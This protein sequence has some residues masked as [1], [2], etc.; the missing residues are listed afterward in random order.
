[1]VL[2]FHILYCFCFFLFTKMVFIGVKIGYNSLCTYPCR[3]SQFF[4]SPLVKA[5]AME[6]EVLAVDS[7][8]TSC[9]LSNFCQCSICKPF[10]ISFIYPF[11][12]I[13]FGPASLLI[14]IYL[15]G[16]SM[17]SFKNFLCRIQP[18][19]AK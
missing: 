10:F 18:S 7:G 11:I 5:E 3:F 17:L 8:A 14:K 4:I 6:R 19:F 9:P 16:F 12:F 15:N 1:M 2:K 13:L